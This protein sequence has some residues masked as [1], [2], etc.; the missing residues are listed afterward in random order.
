MKYINKKRNLENYT[1]RNIPKSVLKKNSEGKTVIDTDSPKYYYGTIPNFKI[2]NEGNFILNNSG[3]KIVNTIDVNIYLTQNLDDMGIFTDK[4]YTPK[5][6]LLT[7]K[8][9]NFNSFSY[10]R[11]AGAP[12]NFYYSNTLQVTGNTDD[13]LL[14][15][16]KS[17]RKNSNGEDIY[18]PNL[19]TSN[20]PKEEFSGV[21]S[22]NSERI[23]YKISANINNITTTG[24]EYTTYKKLT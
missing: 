10:G 22:E 12:L 14:R 4:E 8:P 24:I 23:I 17:Y 5:D 6:T 2:D 1:V 18:V 9:N 3:Q 13:S 21:L 20:N 7:E 16:V 15:Q 19:N 11:L